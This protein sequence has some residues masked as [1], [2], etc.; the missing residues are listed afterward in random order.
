LRD[1]TI[2]HSYASALYDLASR[3]NQAD[4]FA[5]AFEQVMALLAE[6][7]RIQLFLQTPKIASEEKKAALK[8]AFGGRVPPL[9][10]N[11]L[12]VIIDKGRQRLLEEI[13]R[14][15]QQILDENL[16]RVHVDVTLAREADERTEE[17]IGSS[18]SRLLGRTA[19]PHIRVKPEILGGLIVKYGDRVMDGSLRQ[20]LLALK[21]QMLSSR[22]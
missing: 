1:T 2:A 5:H 6:Q 20:R 7:P 18:L 10:L 15:Y 3:H 22:V 21:R 14:E 12:L 4:E 8:S 11:F 13:G 17:E 9:F 16:G 19:I